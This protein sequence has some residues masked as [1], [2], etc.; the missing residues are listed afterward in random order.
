MLELNRRALRCAVAA[1]AFGAG[2]AFAY[3]Y[4]RLLRSS[5]ARAPLCDKA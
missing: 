3:H 1:L 4:G 5:P 2:A